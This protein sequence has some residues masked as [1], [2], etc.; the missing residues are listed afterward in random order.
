[1]R[2]IREG[3]NNVE[4]KKYVKLGCDEIEI[5]KFCYLED[6]LGKYDST[7]KYL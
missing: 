7:G 1:M 3:A 5:A 4:D 2:Q 6:M